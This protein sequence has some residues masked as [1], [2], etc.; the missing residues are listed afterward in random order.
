VDIVFLWENLREIEKDALET[1]SK[2]N[3]SIE[4]V[5]EEFDSKGIPC[6]GVT[7][8]IERLGALRTIRLLSCITYLRK[9]GVT[10]ERFLRKH[11]DIIKNADSSFLKRF[12]I[13]KYSDILAVKEYYLTSEEL[14]SD[15]EE[16]TARRMYEQLIAQI[17][18]EL[19]KDKKELEK[20]FRYGD[21]RRIL[22]ENRWVIIDDNR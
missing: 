2:L 1:L 13:P 10:L 12:I 22:K 15:S 16:E 20:V 9:Q 18:K 19:R 8:A 6:N 14:E 3:K 11:R 21:L 4:L 7:M 5:C 17:S